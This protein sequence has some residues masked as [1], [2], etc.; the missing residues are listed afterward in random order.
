VWCW[1]NNTFGQIGIGTAGAPQTSPVQV[2]VLSTWASVS[3]GGNHTCA[4]QGT[5][6]TLWCWGLNTNGRLGDGTQTQRLVP[7]QVGGQTYWASV[8]AGGSHTCATR[9]NGGSVWCWV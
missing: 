3:A 6:S 7:T 5:D 4:R 9:N 2:G 8:T 1:G